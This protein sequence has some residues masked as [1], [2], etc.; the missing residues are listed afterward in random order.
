MAKGDRLKDRRG[1]PKHNAGIE[2]P[3]P[4]GPV[5][6]VAP[7]CRENKMDDDSQESRWGEI[8]GGVSETSTAKADKLGKYN[9]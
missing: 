8:R 2:T 1:F 5:G 3:T 7:T 6:G 4:A 9:R